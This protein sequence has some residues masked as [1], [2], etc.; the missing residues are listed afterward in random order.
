MLNIS[1]PR[2][3]E[4]RGKDHPRGTRRGHADQA[5]PPQRSKVGKRELVPTGVWGCVALHMEMSGC[6][7]KGQRWTLLADACRGLCLTGTDT[8]RVFLEESAIRLWGQYKCLSTDLDASQAG[9]S[10]LRATRVSADVH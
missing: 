9:C 5:R 8:S 4:M 7:C 1:V 10:K 2:L 3:A 6:G